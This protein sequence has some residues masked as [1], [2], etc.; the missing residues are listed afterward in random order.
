MDRIHPWIGLRWVGLDWIQIFQ[1][2]YG[3]GWIGLKVFL[4][5]FAVMGNS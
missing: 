4:L 2:F 5:L 1:Q 3:L